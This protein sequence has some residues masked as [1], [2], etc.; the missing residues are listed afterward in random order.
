VAPTSSPTFQFDVALSFAG[1]DRTYVD[2]IAARLRSHGVRVF[3]DQYE[4]ATLWGKNLYEHLDYVYQRASRY[5]VL[6]ASSHYAHKA[7]TNHERQSAQARA[8]HERAEY[9]LP[10]RFDDTE[11]P[12]LRSTLAYI[13][14]RSTSRD[15]LVRFILQK[16]DMPL[17]EPAPESGPMRVPRP[18][19]PPASRVPPLRQPPVDQA[20][21]T[22]AQRTER[23]P[24]ALGLPEHLQRVVDERL[25][26]VHRSLE[27]SS[28]VTSRGLDMTSLE[29]L[30]VTSRGPGLRQSVLMANASGLTG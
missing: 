30:H 8:L 16:L 20:E 26:T 22:R 23:G 6:F 27:L 28:D 1:E 29:L 4:Q 7:W 14:A 25:A 13:D 17:A 15:E 2:D 9:I 5:C 18:M 24:Q 12:G 19:S 3:Y 10:V 21:Q 11:I